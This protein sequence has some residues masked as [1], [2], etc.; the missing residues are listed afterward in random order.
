VPILDRY[1][2]LYNVRQELKS[3]VKIN[4]VHWKKTAENSLVVPQ[5]V[6]RNYSKELLDLD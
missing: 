6:L 3:E 4:P 1:N 5:K 2:K